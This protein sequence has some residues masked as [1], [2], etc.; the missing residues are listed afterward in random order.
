MA[1]HKSAYTG[2]YADNHQEFICDYRTDINMLPKC[3]PSSRAFVVEDSSKW[4]QNS[5]GIWKEIVSS[6]SG[7]TSVGDVS[8][9]TDSEVDSMLDD[10]F[11]N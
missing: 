6:S 9:A 8:V 10:V 3:P 4:I 1:I 11:S 7:G 5:E 2:V